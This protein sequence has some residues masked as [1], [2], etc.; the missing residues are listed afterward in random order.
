VIDIQRQLFG[1]S[2]EG[3]LREVDLIVKVYP[4]LADRIQFV[5][6]IQKSK[7]FT[8][9]DPPKTEFES[10]EQQYIVTD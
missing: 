5:G 1:K 6:F 9:M 2:K 8:D 4:S 7:A 3:Y 10:L